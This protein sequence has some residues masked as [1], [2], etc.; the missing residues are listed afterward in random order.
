MQD[1]KIECKC[2]TWIVKDKRQRERIKKDV[3]LCPI[4]G[5]EYKILNLNPNSAKMGHASKFD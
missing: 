2:K 3:S 1:E 4:H 5:R